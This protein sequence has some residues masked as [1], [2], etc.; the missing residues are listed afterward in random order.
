MGQRGGGD[1]DVAE[2]FGEDIGTETH[3]R[4]KMETNQEGNK[5]HGGPWGW[6]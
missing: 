4:R 3:L 6:W 1:G 5:I 2:W